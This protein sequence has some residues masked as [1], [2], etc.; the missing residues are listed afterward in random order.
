MNKPKTQLFTTLGDPSF[1]VNVFE[2]LNN[3]LEI[4]IAWAKQLL[5]SFY[6]DTTMDA[7]EYTEY[8]LYLDNLP[9]YPNNPKSPPYR[10]WWEVSF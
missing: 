8:K 7:S 5:G 6:R 2:A 4:D 9:S 3:A 1:E 10:K